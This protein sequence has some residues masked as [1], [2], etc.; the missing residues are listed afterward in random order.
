MAKDSKPAHGLAN[1]VEVGIGD[2]LEIEIQLQW[3]DVIRRAGS[4]DIAYELIRPRLESGF[5]NKRHAHAA[6]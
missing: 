2:D 6:V 5:V 3:E 1:P 4:D